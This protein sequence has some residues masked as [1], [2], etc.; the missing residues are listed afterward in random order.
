MLC[1]LFKLAP[2]HNLHAQQQTGD[3]NCAPNTLPI[4][5][6]ICIGVSETPAYMYKDYLAWLGENE[7]MKSANFKAAVP[8]YSKWKNLFSNL[9]VEKINERFINS[10]QLALMPIVGITKAQAEAYCKWKTEDFK[11]QLEQMSK[12]ERAQFPQEFK[13]RLP[14]A[15]E[16]GRMRFLMQEKA[17]MKRLKKMAN[18]NRNAFKSSKSK[19]MRDNER[20][21][22][23]YTEMHEKLGFYNLFSNVSEMTSEDGQAIGGSWH[24]PNEKEDFKQVFEYEGAEAW[25]GF[26]IIFEIIK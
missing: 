9:S 5:P 23:I 10:D 26:R 1:F 17:M 3:Y 18:S 2:V 22:D 19:L 15:N 13:F 4:N 7:G 14:T 6:R 20:I 24:K 21:T 25:L 8:D 11:A 16:W 12:R